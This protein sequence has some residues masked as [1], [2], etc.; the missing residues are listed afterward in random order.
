MKPTII[1]SAILS[2][3]RFGDHVFFTLRSRRLEVVGARKNRA[4]ETRDTRISSRALLR[5]ACYT[6]IFVVVFKLHHR[7]PTLLFVNCILF[8][9]H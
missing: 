3:F 4:R 8:D 5:S 9:L 1:F 7:E 6:A 2:L